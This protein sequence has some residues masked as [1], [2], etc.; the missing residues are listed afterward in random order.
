MTR[1]EENTE[2]IISQSNNT[3][4]LVSSND[5]D[6]DKNQ[7]K[8]N[9]GSSTQLQLLHLAKQFALDGALR[10]NDKQMP[11]EDRA[12]KRERLAH[13]R[14][15]QNM[16][17]IIQ[18]TL[19]YCSQSDVVNR[20]DQDWFNSYITLAENVSN[21]T[22]QDLWAKILAGE[23]YQPGTYSLKALQVFRNMSM[24]DAKLLGKACSLAV[25]DQSRTN[26]RLLSGCY[27]KP[28]L[29]N[30]FDKARQKN[31][32]LSQFGLN[33]S[34]LLSLAENHL[35]FIQESETNIL[36]KSELLNFT[37]NGQSFVMA[38]NK[39][40]C[41]LRFYKFTPIGVELS[42]LIND[43]PDATFNTFLRQQLS[44]H[45]SIT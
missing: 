6:I 11:I 15:Q 22:M 23:I 19:A 20:T 29:L 2:V 39:N 27:L 44:H 14:K 43:K 30:M 33:Y 3:T 35:I 4:N 13:L 12:R 37:Y 26:I 38:A 42:Q 8:N 18:K 41:I 10:A 17:V 32:N 45:F 25:K 31:I 34:D 1:S 7:S 28:G 24:G 21:N 9:K 36:S 5:S 40:N 16:E